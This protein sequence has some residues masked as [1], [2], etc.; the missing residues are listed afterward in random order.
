MSDIIQLLPD[1]VAN[2]IAAGEV[3]QRPASVVK[4]LLENAIDAGATNIKLLL[5]DAGKTLIQVIDDGKGMST[6]DSRMCFERHA[7]SKIK[8]AEDLFNLNTKGFRG[9]ALASIAAIAHVE[10]KTKQENE[11]LGAQLKIEGSKIISQDFISTGKGTSLSVKNLFYNIPA[12]RNFLKSDTIETRHIIDE[13]QRV[14][15]AHSNISFLL[16]HN[17]NEVYHLK[18]SNLRKRIVAIF[19]T[20]MNEKLV[21]IQ[22]QTDILTIEGFVAKPE[23]SKRK[24]GEQFFF[25]ND[26]FIK[27]SYLNHAVV[28]AFDGLLEQ[29]SHP[30][31]FLYLKVPANTIDINIHPTKT[32]IKFDN[33]KALYAMLRA[34]VKHSLGQYNVAPLL[35]F[36][37]DANLDTSYHLNTNRKS[38]KTP[39]ISVDPDFNPFKELEQKEIT[40]PYRREKQTESWESLYTSVAITDEQ[41]QEELFENQQE[42]KTQKTFQ[43]Q[44]KYLLSSI[45]SGVVLINQSLA[46]QRILYEQFLESITV[47]EANSQQLLF[48]VKISFSSAEIE[49]IYTIKTEL[50]NAGFSFDEFTKDSVIIKGIPVSVTESKITIILE[51]LLNDI[52]LEVPDASFSHFDVMAKSFARTL[53]IKTGTL[54]SEK[55]QESLVNNL[56]SCKE[57]TVSPFGKATF[58]TLT[59]NEIDSLFNS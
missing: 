51:E 49:M 46:H 3:V 14:A 27:S 9:E 52:N 8:K 20:K 40:F 45:K 2:Q 35:D 12:R 21:P 1:H 37:R 23:F 58:K 55:E 31:Y 47:K 57:P 39:Q 19:G 13:F 38:T 7:T 30:S 43:I 15:L 36:N 24:R 26:R 16:H 50:E 44:R 41:K 34:T 10:L 42:I 4:E 17:N 6:T 18:S 59:L 53:S 25:V 54:L 32:E 33:E 5:K 28:N 56:F 22:E 29:G 48:P 11:E